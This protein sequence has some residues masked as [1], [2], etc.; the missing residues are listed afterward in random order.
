MRSCFVAILALGSAACAGA[1]VAAPVAPTLAYALPAVNPATYLITDTTR[2]LVTAPGERSVETTIALRGRVL[3]GVHVDSVGLLASVRFDSVSGAFTVGAER[4]MTLDSADLPVDAVML[5]LAA[6]G[7]DSLLVTPVFSAALSRISGGPSFVRHLFVSL[8]GRAVVPGTVWTDT[9][10]LTEEDE[11]VR[12]TTRAI[13]TSVLQGDTAI[14]GHTVHVI[15]SSI[16]MSIEVSGVVDD[17][18]VVQHLTGTSTA[19]TLW[20]DVRSLLVQREEHGT[21]SG[22]MDLPALGVTGVPVRASIHRTIGLLP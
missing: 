3:L 1:P 22:T 11:G 13:V 19:Q 15:A 14:D 7:A 4:S 10:T 8:P 12:S 20:D 9:L 17:L 21:A 5:R 6:D 2:I 16:A 18:E